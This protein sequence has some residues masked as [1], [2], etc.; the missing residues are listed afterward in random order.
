[1][2]TLSPLAVQEILY[3]DNAWDCLIQG[4]NGFIILLRLGKT[5]R[6]YDKGSSK[7]FSPKLKCCYSIREHSLLDS[8]ISHEIFQNIFWNTVPAVTEHPH[9][10]QT[11]KLLISQPLGLIAAL[12][13]AFFFFFYRWIQEEIIALWN[14]SLPSLI[15]IVWGR[16]EIMTVLEPKINISTYW[17]I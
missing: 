8:R 14:A 1:M 15:C 13:W 7:H 3:N 16:G 10:N 17:S 12:P 11:P 5:K 9:P 4:C 6:P 2:R